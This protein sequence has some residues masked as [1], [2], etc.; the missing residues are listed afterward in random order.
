MVWGLV[1]GEIDA[2][3]DVSIPFAPCWP[4]GVCEEWTVLADC[5]SV[6]GVSLNLNRLICVGI[7]GHV[8]MNPSA[9]DC[10]NRVAVK[11]VHVE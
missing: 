11:I 3:G 6:W 1:V 8:E 2:A 5:P 7:E 4:K 9:A 10:D